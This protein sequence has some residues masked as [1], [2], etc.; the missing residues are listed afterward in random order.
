MTDY[1]MHGKTCLISGATSG[2][3][4][5]TALGLAHLGAKVIVVGRNPRRISSTIETIQQASGNMQVTCLLAD[6]S[7]Q[8][9]VRRLAL[10][11]LQQGTGLDVLVNNVGAT[12]LSYQASPDGIELTWALNYL[13]HFLLTNLLVDSLKRTAVEHGEARVIEITSSMYRFSK[14]RFD[15]RQN[16]RR[17]NGV[18]AYAQSKRAM[19]TFACELARRLQDSHVAVN[20][21]TPG[22]VAT[23]VADQNGGWASLAMRILNRFALPVEQGVKPIVYLASSP[24]MA[25][26]TGQYFTK[27]RKAAL[28]PACADTDIA[29]NLWKLSQDM[30]CR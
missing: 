29:T 21:I 22:L 26:I 5:A 17:Y 8:A 20:S 2:I 4:Q 28:D 27:F 25:G 18:L 1:T 7:S 9:Q 23:K 14:P 11:I 16:A 24:E 10:E 13:N 12:N 3:G 6:L 19:V 15:R 30:L